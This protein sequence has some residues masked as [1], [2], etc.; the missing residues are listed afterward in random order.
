MQG[1]A[2]IDWREVAPGTPRRDV[3][4]QLVRALAGDDD[5]VLTSACPVCGG[6][7]HG[8][9]RASWSHARRPP[10][11]SVA[12]ARDDERTI[13]VAGVV[14]D[15]RVRRFGIDAEFAHHARRDGV[16]LARITVS[17]VPATVRSWVRA[18]AALK[19]DGRGLRV[20]PARVVLSERR[21]LRRG[22]DE[23]RSWRAIVPGRAAPARGRDAAGP[24]GV[25]V[26]IAW[27]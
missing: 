1:P 17:G 15:E 22:R 9:L 12:Y 3:A 19:A 7:D 6:T 20:D 5:L 23:A 13:A 11:V 21:G 27:W 10:L 8:P 25:L 26:A 2:R 14:H 24:D 16:G 4:Q 18:E